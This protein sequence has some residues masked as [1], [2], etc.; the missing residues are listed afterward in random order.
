MIAN[1]SKKCLTQNGVNCVKRKQ[2]RS[3]TGLEV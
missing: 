1:I 3:S 2:T